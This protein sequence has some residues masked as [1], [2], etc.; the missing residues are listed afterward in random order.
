MCMVTAVS[1]VTTKFYD[2]WRR[3]MVDIETLEFKDLDTSEFKDLN[4]V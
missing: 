1:Q 3:F 2:R 4:R